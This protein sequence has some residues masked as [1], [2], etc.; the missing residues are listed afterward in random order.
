MTITFS[1]LALSHHNSRDKKNEKGLGF[2]QRKE[3]KSSLGEQTGARL[4]EIRSLNSRE[5][6]V[7]IFQSCSF[8]DSSCPFHD[9]LLALSHRLNYSHQIGSVAGIRIPAMRESKKKD[10]AKL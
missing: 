8:A 9:F 6:S 10:I 3:K 2:K 5:T 1:T 4:N 7:R